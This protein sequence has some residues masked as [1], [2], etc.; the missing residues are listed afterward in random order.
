MV[1]ES[2]NNAAKHAQA[3]KLIV[4]FDYYANR[5]LTCSIK[6]NGKGLSSAGSESTSGAPTR[7]RGLN[8]MHERLQLIRTIYPAELKINS[9]ENQGCEVVISLKLRPGA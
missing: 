3:T 4:R 2:V 9:Q 5:V 6:D 1:Q 8:N 7:S